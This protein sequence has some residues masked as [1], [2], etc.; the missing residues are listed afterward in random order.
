MEVQKLEQSEQSSDLLPRQKLCES[1]G[2]QLEPIRA[3]S[4]KSDT[5]GKRRTV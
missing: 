2:E 1:L 4:A 3:K 5:W